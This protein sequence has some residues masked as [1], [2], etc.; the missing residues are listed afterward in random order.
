MISAENRSKKKILLKPSN[1]HVP[2]RGV[3]QKTPKIR[4]N[5]F[6]KL[7]K[8]HKIIN[9]QHL[10]RTNPSMGYGHRETAPKGGRCVCLLVAIDGSRSVV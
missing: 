2:N 3:M 9:Q 8:F 5:L 4:L 7:A 10:S 1:A 6:Q